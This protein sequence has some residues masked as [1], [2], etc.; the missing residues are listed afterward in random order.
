MFV[1]VAVTFLAALIVTVQVPVVLV[2]APLHPEND[3][4]RAGEAVRVTEVP[5][6]Y[7]SVQSAPQLIPVGLEVIVPDPVPALAVVSR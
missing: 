3:E 6:A 7:D 4:S 1:N 2:Q 5:E